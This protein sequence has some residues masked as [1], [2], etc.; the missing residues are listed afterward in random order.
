MLMPDDFG[1]YTARDLA[2]EA[3]R[4]ARMRR[5]VYQNR[6]MTG[7]MTRRDADNKIT[8]MEAI[9]AHFDELARKER[10]L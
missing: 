8:M 2:R 5:T 4:E 6:V 1:G 7:R 10:L 9:A 3:E